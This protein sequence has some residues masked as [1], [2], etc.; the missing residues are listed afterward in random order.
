MPAGMLTAGSIALALIA[1]AA[2]MRRYRRT[3]AD[4]VLPGRPDL[5]MRFPVNRFA[6]AGGGMALRINAL[7]DEVGAT[8][9]HLFARGF[10]QTRLSDS[11]KND[12]G[13]MAEAADRTGALAE[14][15]AASMGEMAAIVD[16]IAR[17]V[18]KTSG[19]ARSGNDAPAIRDS[20]L[21]SVQK[22]ALQISTWAET[23]KALSRASKDIAGFIKVISEIARQTNLLALNAAIEAARAGEKGRGFAVVA[24]EVRKLADRTAQQTKEIAGTLGIIQEKAEDSLRNMEATLSIVAESITKAQATDESLRQISTK[25]SAIAADVSSNMTEV[26]LHANNARALAERIVQS[27]DAVARGTLDIY[28]HLCAFRVDDA[29]RTAEEFLV[30]A[31]A[32]LREMVAADLAA[33]KVRREDLFDENYTRIEGDRFENRASAYFNTAVLPR[34]KEWS[35]AHRNTIYVVAM[36]RNGFMP[37]HVMPARTGVIMKDAVSQKGARSLKLI[38]QAFRRPLEAGGQL[39][40]D[41]ACP[42]TFH[43]LHWGCLRIGYLPF[44]DG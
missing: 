35:A 13:E 18:H 24:G 20:S 14:Q 33:G 40:V 37:A 44:V 32:R 26:T 19:D 2:A 28:S 16:E 9:K 6:G 27:G 4:E 34:L 42:L 25:A 5:G 39:V 36:D 29:D 3:G 38:G 7:L 22:L 31:A 8:L 30:T 11:V 1:A 41:V 12:A 23:N 21:E 10:E 43:E 15:V 17:S